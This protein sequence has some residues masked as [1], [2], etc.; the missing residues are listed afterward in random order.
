MTKQR[1]VRRRQCERYLRHYDLFGWDSTIGVMSVSRAAIYR[2]CGKNP[3]NERA[4]F[5]KLVASNR[6]PRHWVRRQRYKRG[7]T[8][9][10]KLA[11]AQAIERGIIDP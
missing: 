4:R 3:K 8:E 6:N 7:L 2:S 1:N 11:L 9:A 5:R 10:D